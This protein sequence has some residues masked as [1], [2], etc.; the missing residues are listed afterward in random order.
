MS[1][2]GMLSPYREQDVTVHPEIDQLRNPAGDR[3]V[4]TRTGMIRYLNVKGSFSLCVWQDLQ[5]LVLCFLCFLFSMGVER[6]GRAKAD[7][8][9]QQKPLS[10]LLFSRGMSVYFLRT[11]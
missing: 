6:R 5:R 3:T 2:M 11:G 4:K 8:R 10:S 9:H 7:K 1:L